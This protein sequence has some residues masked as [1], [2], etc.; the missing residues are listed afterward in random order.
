MPEPDAKGNGVN[1]N[2]HW[3]HQLRNIGKHVDL[4]LNRLGLGQRLPGQPSGEL[5]SQPS[6]VLYRPFGSRAPAVTAVHRVR[7]RHYDH[8][9]GKDTR[10]GIEA[11]TEG[12]LEGLCK[13]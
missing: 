7:T 8:H 3:T 4:L 6:A 9:Y 2:E 1:F 11:D 12:F 5:A 10:L 13:L